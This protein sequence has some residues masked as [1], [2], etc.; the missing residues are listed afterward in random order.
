M[1]SNKIQT[2]EITDA[3]DV[4]SNVDIIIEIKNGEI[5]IMSSSPPKK[6]LIINDDERVII[7]KNIRDPFM[8]I[9]SVVKNKLEKW[10][11]Q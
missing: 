1:S 7:L 5:N 6:F 8:I 11:K 10:K 2:E 3:K 4:P 9:S